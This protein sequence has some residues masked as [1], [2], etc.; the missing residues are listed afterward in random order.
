MT[1]L[2]NR[3]RLL[4]ILIA[5]ILLSFDAYAKE[6]ITEGT[7]FWFGIPNLHKGL[8]E[9]PRGS[10]TGAS[11]ELFISSKVPTSVRLYNSN[12]GIIKTI[13]VEANTLKIVPLPSGYQSTISEVV[14]DNKSFYVESDNPIS[15]TVYIAWYKT[16]E[17]FQIIPVDWL[18][19]DYITLNLYQDRCRM[20]DNGTIEGGATGGRT[21]DHPA[22]ILIVA[23][24]DNT[25]V[26]YYPTA[27]TEKVKAGKAGTVILS[28]GQTF[29]IMGDVSNPLMYQYEETDIT[30]TRIHATKNIAVYSGHTKSAFPKFAPSYYSSYSADF[31]R[32]MLFDSMW[33]VSM[34][35]KEYVTAPVKY[36]NRRYQHKIPDDEGD[37]IR[38]VA[39]EDSTTVYEMRADGSGWNPM[40]TG[41]KRGEY[42]DIRSRITPGYFKSNKKIQVGQYAKG[43]FWWSGDI[44]PKTEGG[45]DKE[46]DLLNPPESGEGMLMTVTPNGHWTNHASFASIPSQS[47]F[48]TLIF[49]TGD[50]NYINLDGA[51][52]KQTFG[53]KIKAIVGS[54]YSYLSEQ[55]AKG[56]HF[57]Q[58][59]QEDALFALYGYGNIDA[60]KDGFAYGYSAG[61]NYSET[62][63][64]SL[65][66]SSNN[67]SIGKMSGTVEA[68]DLL[69][70]ANC[71]KILTIMSDSSLNSKLTYTINPDKK[72]ADFNITFPDLAVDGYLKLTVISKSGSKF[73]KEFIYNAIPLSADTSAQNY[74]L[75]E[76]K[77]DSVR[78][79]TI[80]N[81]GIEPLTIDS[82][83]LL[84]NNGIFRINSIE[85]KNIVL[86]PGAT[87]PYEIIARF[88]NSNI[89]TD[90]AQLIASINKID[91][92][93]VDLYAEYNT[94]ICTIGSDNWKKVKLYIDQPTSKPVAIKNDGSEQLKITSV[95]FSK[96]TSSFNIDGTPEFLVAS[97]STPFLV[98]PATTLNFGVTYN[99][100]FTSDTA[101]TNE[102]I[103]TFA[104]NA[105]ITVPVSASYIKVPLLSADSDTLKFTN[106]TINKVFTLD[107]EIRNN[108]NADV[109]INSI[110]LTGTNSA[111]SYG[112]VGLATNS[113]IPKNSSKTVQISIKLSSQPT[114]DLINTLRVKYMN[115]TQDLFKVLIPKSEVTNSVEELENAS[116]LPKG[117]Y[118]QNSK[119]LFENKDNAITNIKLWNETGKLI[120]SYEVNSNSYELS[121]EDLNV[122]V[123]LYQIQFGNQ[124]LKG[125]F[126]ITPLR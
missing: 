95:K 2:I 100:E 23:T 96:G 25:E 72:T 31:L 124:I 26:E 3:L 52:I 93:L 8:K 92:P 75:R 38:F 39:T 88:D 62:C 60:H 66:I 126:L 17:A 6:S 1:H 41:L 120:K 84:N 58:S 15:L 91:M 19:T 34:L 87:K 64:D 118:S 108:S 105:N 37:L 65:Y 121:A 4:T 14:T 78:I 82:L 101:E 35:G 119:L 42:Y 33:P 98:A 103:I 16:G 9:L 70:D 73:S 32:N 63:A 111:C 97:L 117:A 28:K 5:I 48:F 102:L 10:T 69:S 89:P 113:I 18:G 110:N 56:A 79:I 53:N 22:Q 83:F 20:I 125:N 13:V 21:L 50:E 81:S 80:S 114:T 99:P 68:F 115:N 49:K 40:R 116:T 59:T 7:S 11:E 77:K 44:V 54:P 30:G 109:E 76:T 29:L 46:D 24:E 36:L 71:A 122:G 55:S 104:N 106:L 74:E 85:L 90:T 123:Y 27:N 51:N 43:W 86:A 61:N 12:G 45:T 57:V 47:N 67:T 94:A 107:K 112:I